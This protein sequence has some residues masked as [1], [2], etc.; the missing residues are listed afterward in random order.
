M[1]F[2]EWIDTNY[3]EPA[4]KRCTNEFETIWKGNQA[5]ILSDFIENSL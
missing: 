3:D 4:T 5:N 2:F 1:E